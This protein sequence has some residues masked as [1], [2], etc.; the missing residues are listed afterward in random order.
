MRVGD[1]IIGDVRRGSGT[2]VEGPDTIR[3]YLIFSVMSTGDLD[4]LREHRIAILVPH[5]ST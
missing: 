5:L 3:L 1:G 2:F 4:L